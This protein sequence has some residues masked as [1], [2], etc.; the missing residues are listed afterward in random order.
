MC[1]LCE[2]HSGK[3]IDLLFNGNSYRIFEP[4]FYVAIGIECLFVL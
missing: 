3:S 2:L 1:L 4:T